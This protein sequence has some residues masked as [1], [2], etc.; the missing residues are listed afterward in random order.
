VTSSTSIF[1]RTQ[2]QERRP[3]VTPGRGFV[4]YLRVS[5][6]LARLGGCGQPTIRCR[7]RSELDSMNSLD[8]SQ[9]RLYDSLNLPLR[10]HKVLVFRT[11]EEVPV[12]P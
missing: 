12:S 8:T 3:T 1:S 7:S 4:N 10:G 6:A 5:P 9:N 11:A 2:G